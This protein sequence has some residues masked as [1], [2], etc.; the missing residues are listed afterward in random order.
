MLPGSNGHLL[1]LETSF[2]FQVKLIQMWM[3]NATHVPGEKEKDYWQSGTCW[4]EK[5]RLSRRD[6]SVLEAHGEE[7][8]TTV[9]ET[10][11]DS[12]YG[13]S[14]RGH[15]RREDDEDTTAVGNIQSKVQ[16]HYRHGNATCLHSTASSCDLK[17]CGRERRSWLKSEW[18][19][20]H[21][22]GKLKPTGFSITFPKGRGSS[23]QLLKRDWPTRC[24][25]VSATVELLGQ[26]CREFHVTWGCWCSRFW[27]GHPCFC[28]RCFSPVSNPNKKSVVQQV[29]LWCNRYFSLPCI[30]FPGWVDVCFIL[31]QGIFVKEKL[32]LID[33][34]V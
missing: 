33:C 17:H 30:R 27:A 19:K 5:D 14:E 2:Y 13:W 18:R 10:T 7:W 34:A 12:S 23:K 15:E 20:L 9:M 29:G 16:L 1:L 31:P 25:E 22:A 26:P 6:I 4:G 21:T 32:L 11:R 8:P 24:R 28:K 3:G